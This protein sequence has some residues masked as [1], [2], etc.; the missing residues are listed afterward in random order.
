M[1]SS[2]SAL[3]LDPVRPWFIEGH[4]QVWEIEG[5]SPSSHGHTGFIEMS[6]SEG[7]S[8]AT[9]GAQFAERI[10]NTISEPDTD[11]LINALSAFVSFPSV[12]GKVAEKENCRQAAIW[13][14]KFLTELGADA[15]LVRL[16]VWAR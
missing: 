2:R 4:L 9:N 5:P 14:R 10:H 11:I 1:S 13:L 6:A 8:K 12:S 3:A 16:V 7:A 15:N